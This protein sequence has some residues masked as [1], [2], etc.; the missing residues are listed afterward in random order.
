[1]LNNLLI[2]SLAFAAFS[3]AARAQDSVKWYDWDAAGNGC[4]QGTSSV[5]AAGDEIAWTFDAF[6]FDLK[7]G[8]QATGMF[9]RVSTKIGVEKGNY[10]SQFTQELSYAG[11]KTKDDSFLQVGAY[12]HFYGFELPPLIRSYENGVPFD[13]VNAKLTETYWKIPGL[14]PNFFCWGR[15]PEGVFES[16]LSAIGNIGP[17]GTASLT[18]QGLNISFKAATILA[19]C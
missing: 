17:Y 7:N 4:P 15:D 18:I 1:M 10:V 3:A 2:S 9:C 19:R 5:I 14:E 8:P 11:T 6:S 16:T 12:S 13:D